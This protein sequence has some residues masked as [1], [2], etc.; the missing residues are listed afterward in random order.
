MQ[1]PK[2]AHAVLHKHFAGKRCIVTGGASGIGLSVVHELRKY[3][4][5]VLAVD[6]NRN[7]LQKLR[8][9]CTCKPLYPIS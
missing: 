1:K 2:Q 8:Q 7:A 6:R 5:I 9:K 3:G 4:A